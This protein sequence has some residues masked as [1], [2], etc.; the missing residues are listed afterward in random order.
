MKISKR[1]KLL[2]LLPLIILPLIFVVLWSIKE[3]GGGSDGTSSGINLNL[4]LV[5]KEMKDPE[6]KMGHYKKAEADSAKWTEQ[7]KK[8]PYYD[9]TLE[10]SMPIGIA[11]RSEDGEDQTRLAA[12]N[13][14][15][16]DPNEEMVYRK[17]AELEK[18][19]DT[20]EAPE[21]KVGP[22]PGMETPTAD[23]ERLEMM[24]EQMTVREDE[25]PELRQLGGMLETILDIQHP[26]RVQ[27]KL[28]E[29]SRENKGKVYAVIPQG[30]KMPISVMDQRT[31]T[32]EGSGFFGLEPFREEGNFQNT[33]AALIHETRS[34]TSGATVKLR[35]DQDI[36]VAGERIPKGNFVFGTA[37]ISG[38]RLK[39][40][41]DGIRYK[42]SLF[43]VDLEAYGTDGNLGLHVPGAMARKVAKESSGR[44]VQGIGPTSFDTSLE[45][46]AAS[47]GVEATKNLLSRKAKLI[48]VTVKAGDL[49]LLKDKKFKND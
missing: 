31:R 13:S 42:N 34:L 3:K 27:H 20:P 17:L 22:R 35:L 23:I 21:K 7:A 8:D 48:K 6:D 39:I 18:I 24:M 37:Q 29:L 28:E 15:Y 30:K 16:N 11:T 12:P 9:R 40:Q 38:E 2:L 19:L 10:R 25:D 33:I 49:V 43:P 14:S 45:A 26:Q 32:A 5:D 46:Q 41:I 1:Q 44:A 47:A 36:Y 4:P